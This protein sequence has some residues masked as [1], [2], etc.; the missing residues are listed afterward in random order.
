[1]ANNWWEIKILCEPALE[2]LVMWRLD[3]FGCRGSA[4]E[5]RGPARLMRGYLPQDQAN[6]LDLAALVLLLRQDALIAAAPGI[7]S[8]S[9]AVQWDLI[10]EEDWSSSWKDHWHPQEVGDRLLIQPAWLTPTNVGNRAILRL[11]PGTAFG[12]GAHPTTQLSLEALE[13]RLAGARPDAELILADIGC[14]SG[15]LSIGALLLGAKRIY[16][17]D[18]DPLAVKASQSN[19]DLNQLNEEQMPV[20]LG[21]VDLLSRTLREPLDGFACNILAEVIIDLV[22][23]FGEIMKPTS[24]GVLSGILMEQAKPVADMLEQHGWT[25]ATLWRR[26]DWCCL[27]IRR[28]A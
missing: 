16:A 12:T 9:P 28:S 20:A 5:V 15:I 2:E 14:G 25:V 6:P 13:M 24:W 7:S 19:R 18:T 8:N 22:P 27:T 1:M 10:E 3:T 4:S 26:G 17:V 21:S 11:D 23:H